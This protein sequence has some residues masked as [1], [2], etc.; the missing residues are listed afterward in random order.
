MFNRN[1]ILAL[2]TGVML[3][4]ASFAQVIPYPETPAEL[5]EKGKTITAN[6]QQVVPQ[7]TLPGQKIPY[8][9]RSNQ[10]ERYLVSGTIVNYMARHQDSG[11][12][13]EMAT[14]TGGKESGQPVHHHNDHFISLYLMD[15]EAEL[16]LNNEKFLMKRGDFA[17]IPTGIDYGFRF[18]RHHNKMLQWQSGPGLLPVYQAIGE[19]TDLHIQPDH[20]NVSWSKAE[21]AKAE[22]AGDIVFAKNAYPEGKA[23]EITRKELPHGVVPYTL[24]SGEGRKFVGGPEFFAILATQENTDGRYF[25]VIT[26]APETEWVPRHYHNLHS[27]NFFALEGEVDMVV[28]HSKT[29]LKAGDYAAVP[30]GT[31]HSYKMTTPYNRFLGFLTPGL[32][33]KFFETL[34]DEG[35][36]ANVYPAEAHKLR[37]DRVLGE[38][39]SLDLVI[40]ED[41]MRKAES[42]Q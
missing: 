29:T 35:Y 40:V 31:I 33:Q 38:L 7:E 30:A 21:M 37:F 24:A 13:F 10:G 42:A 14:I 16:W 20:A 8:I 19:Q 34:G 41:E 2:T 26:Q 28:N 23:K 32:F 36:D 18:A 1:Q 12:M 3:S 4:A 9:S 39:E 11:D 17:N 25:S 6:I 27:E 5:L 22:K 15:G